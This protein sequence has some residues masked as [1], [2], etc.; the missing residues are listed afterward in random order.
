MSDDE[1]HSFARLARL[2]LQEVDG[3][4]LTPYHGIVADL[5]NDFSLSA[6][7]RAFGIARD[8]YCVCP[9]CLSERSGAWRTAWRMGWSVCCRAHSCPLIGS[10]PACGQQLRIAPGRSG[11]K[12]DGRGVVRRPPIPGAC[13]NFR[14]HS[15]PAD[16]AFCSFDLRTATATPIGSDDRL[17]GA[18]EQV[19]AML[20]G[21]HPATRPDFSLPVI[22]AELRAAIRLL[23]NYAQL[24]DLS[25]AL[26]VARET[27]ARH[28]R[29]RDGLAKGE[30]AAR[31]RPLRRAPSD[32]A[33]TAAVL[34]DAVEIVLCPDDTSAVVRLTALARRA[35]NSSHALR[36]APGGLPGRLA[37]IWH[38][39]KTADPRSRTLRR[40]ALAVGGLA[41]NDAVPVPL[42]PRHIPQLFWADAYEPHLAAFF[43]E[44]PPIWGREFCSLALVCALS[45]GSWTEAES[46]FEATAQKHDSRLHRRVAD[47]GG[48]EPFFAALR[49]AAIEHAGTST[50]VDYAER[51]RLLAT[52]AGFDLESW[53]VVCDAALTDDHASDSMRLRASTWVWAEL[54]GGSSRHC[55][56]FA[57][58]PQSYWNFVTT[59]LPRYHPTLAIA[60]PL[61]LTAHVAEP[62]PLHVRLST[63]LPHAAARRQIF[64]AAHAAICEHLG[65]GLNE[66]CSRAPDGHALER[67]IAVAAVDAATDN[68]TAWIAN[69]LG[70]TRRCLSE[71]RWRVRRHL[72]E[73][74]A[75]QAVVA[76]FFAIARTAAETAANSKRTSPFVLPAWLQAGMSRPR[77]DG[78]KTAGDGCRSPTRG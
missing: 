62:A 66:L 24:E 63:D 32:P 30:Q 21:N 69:Q 25:C 55:H 48:M 49:A 17:L 3:L 11:V 56:L 71:S 44:T 73:D 40:R 18:Q 36:T 37:D 45:G 7:D 51:R 38:R 43:A 72:E 29:S 65:V 77:R 22:F 61:I 9:Q 19:D 23:L 5:S 28:E 35:R 6:I 54:T 78:T 15:T 1:R 57:G 12:V 31:P 27:Y 42:E 60:M 4:L 34:A 46:H 39:A 10:C 53:T 20:L 59:I 76:E 58:Q 8:G 2:S 75:S 74:P 50:S 52:W 33:L 47:N 67:H 70:V 16:G 14:P 13:P 68:S 26:E 41:P 64:E